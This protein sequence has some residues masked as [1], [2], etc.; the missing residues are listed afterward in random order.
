MRWFSLEL[1]LKYGERGLSPGVVA[2]LLRCSPSWLISLR[3]LHSA[4]GYAAV[5]PNLISVLDYVGA[6]GGFNLAGSGV[7]PA[8]G[9]ARGLQMRP[10]EG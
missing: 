9:P 5:A 1:T 4:G 7:A 3:K 6:D 10:S 8:G 2:G